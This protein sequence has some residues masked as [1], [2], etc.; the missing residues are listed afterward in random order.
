MKWPKGDRFYRESECGQYR[1]TKC[2]VSGK[3]RYTLFVRKGKDFKL[4]GYPATDTFEEA[5]GY[6]HDTRNHIEADREVRV[7]D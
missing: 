5:E 7:E 1:I 6:L 2:Y 3:P 4:T